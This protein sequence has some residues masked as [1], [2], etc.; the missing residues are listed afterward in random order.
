MKERLGVFVVA[1]M[2]TFGAGFVFQDPQTKRQG[3]TGLKGQKITTDKDKVNA[4]MSDLDFVTKVAK[5]GKTEVAAGQLALSKASSADVKQFA[6][7]MIDDHTK[8]NSE[9]MQLAQTK[10]WQLPPDDMAAS[11]AQ[12]HNTSLSDAAMA[13]NQ[14][15]QADHKAKLDKLSKLSGAEFDRE[16]MTHMV[17]DHDKAVAMFE[18]K[19][20]SKDGDD[21][22]ED[23]A[24]KTLPTLREHRRLAREIAGKV[25]AK[26]PADDAAKKGN[27]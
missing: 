22:L 10:G 20:N 24:E 2:F 15:M 5:N 4:Q 16:Y 8:A 21:A 18:S 9:L 13:D 11:T 19:A 17:M 6:Q 3:E 26:V 1:V 25:G 27:R 14:K 23:W 12:L 7:R